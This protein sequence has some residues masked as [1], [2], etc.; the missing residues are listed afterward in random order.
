MRARVASVLALAFVASAV[1]VQDLQNFFMSP[2]G[3]SMTTTD[4][5]SLAVREAGYLTNCSVTVPMLQ[6]LRDTLYASTSLGFSLTDV[7]TNLL[8]LAYQHVDPKDL[9]ALFQTLYS[10]S[11][12]GLPRTLAQ[13]NAMGLAQKHAE[14]Y[15]LG[16]LYSVLY[17]VSGVNLP[18]TQAQQMA[19]DL[20][21]AGADAGRLQASYLD[22]A[23]RMTKDAAL[24]VA[25]S[26]AVDF[27]LQ[28][29]AARYAKDGKLYV[30]KEFQS[31]YG[32]QWLLE[33]QAG[34]PEKRTSADG[35]DYTAAEYLQF[36]GASWVSRWNVAPVAVQRRISADGK[37]Y[38][39][40]EFQQFYGNAW[41]TEWFKSYEVL[42]SCAGLN[43]YSCATMPR[44]QW[45]PTGDVTT[46]CV[47]RPLQA[48][49]E[50]VV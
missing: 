31:Y 9:S 44:C 29:L 46:S 34:V 41:Q 33:W 28:G 49:N 47:A 36:F 40:Q 2:N 37:T 25:T 43:Q 5:Y 10:V 6:S 19:I 4:A 22:N 23:R 7:R 18:R 27:N 48:S 11:S 24:Q 30:A 42:D 17:S 8:P 13:S 3:L 39:L 1:Q 14:P 16:P 35:L 20:T 50:L 45:K 21:A 12:V 38:T 15:L 26:D 32:A